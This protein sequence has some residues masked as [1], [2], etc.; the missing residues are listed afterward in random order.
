MTIVP[1][2]KLIPA[3]TSAGIRRS[4]LDMQYTE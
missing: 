2:R 4:G 1:K 3:A